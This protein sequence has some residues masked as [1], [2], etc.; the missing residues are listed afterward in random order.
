M[1]FSTGQSYL[2]G[3]GIHGE[4]GFIGCMKNITVDD[5]YNLEEFDEATVGIGSCNMVDRC[6][7]NPCEHN[8]ICKQTSQEFYCECENTG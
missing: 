1:E 6:T 4:K 8:G 2:I 3:G 7:P 5:N